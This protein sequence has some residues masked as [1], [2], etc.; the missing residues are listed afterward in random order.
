M[1]DFYRRAWSEVHLDRLKYNFSVCKKNLQPD[2]EIMAVVKAN[3]YGHCDKVIAPYLQ[4]LGCKWFAVSNLKEAIHIRDA[5]IDQ[6]ILML[7]YSSPEYTSYIL[8]YDI[9]QT[10]TSLE[11]AKSFE[12]HIPL[13]KKIK[14]HVKI[15]TGMD[16]LGLKYDTIDEYCDIIEKI[17]KL[18]YISLEGI[19]THFA[20]ADSDQKDDVEYTK[21]Q[22][23]LFSDIVNELENRN[24]FIKYKHIFNSAGATYYKDFESSFARYGI[25]LYGLKP[26]YFTK[27]PEELKPVMELKT[28][29]THIKNIS[30][31]DFVGYGRNFEAQDDMKIATLSIGYADGYSRLLSSKSY[32][33]VNGKKAKSIGSICMDQMMIDVTNI[34]VKVGD[35]ATLF[36]SDQDKFILADELANLSGTIGYEI[37]CGITQRVPRIIIEDGKILDVIE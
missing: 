10:I 16:R 29:V 22:Q 31:G 35:T 21:S 2:C 19:F 18:S 20:V 14:A 1:C 37:V 27:L 15:D 23:K 8:D 3:A 12:K 7:G 36:G 11:H 28:I 33:L 17:N 6:N 5:G 9:N 4:K 30:K 24:I 34:N 25:M 13:N 26:N 32:V